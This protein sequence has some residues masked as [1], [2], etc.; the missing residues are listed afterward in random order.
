MN[1]A[2]GDRAERA[3]RAAKTASLR[4]RKR[5]RMVGWTAGALVAVPLLFGAV[6]ARIAVSEELKRRDDLRAERLKLERSSLELEGRL[7]K[8]STWE[9]VAPRAR[10]IGLRPPQAR[11][12]VW[13]S[14]PD[15]KGRKG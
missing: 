14:V 5:E 12:V 6:W 2:T 11:E 10:R 7:A 1:R 8:L 9:S 4:R 3:G 15:R 13:V